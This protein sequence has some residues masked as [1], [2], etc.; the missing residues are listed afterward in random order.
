MNA[1]STCCPTQQHAGGI[2]I[3]APG[4]DP[5][6]QLKK[7]RSVHILCIDDDAQVREFMTQCLTHF[8]HRVTVAPGGKRGLE[9]FRTATL[10]NQPYEVV[11]T[12][13]GM[14]DI[15]GQH[16]ARA[17]KAESPNTPVIMMTG[18]GTFMEDEGE[19][20]LPV[21][22]VVGKPPRIQE[23]NDMVLQMATSATPCS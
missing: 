13:L 20:A 4:R 9:M 1:T 15:D 17:I 22:A 19:T 16:V 12:D 7:K 11:I 14:P 2:A 18:W 21:D 5:L 8:N 6:P 3:D 23:L 10:E